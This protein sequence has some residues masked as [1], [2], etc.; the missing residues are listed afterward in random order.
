MA[1]GV[2]STVLHLLGLG[3][4]S[5][6]ILG[7]WTALIVAVAVA[8]CRP[9]VAPTPGL[10]NSVGYAIGVPVSIPTPPAVEILETEPSQKADASGPRVSGPRVPG[11]DPGKPSQPNQPSAEQPDPPTALDLSAPGSAPTPTHLP[12]PPTG[13]PTM[14]PPATPTTVP[15]PTA[16]PLPTATPLPPPTAT[17]LPP[18]TQTPTVQPTAT[19]LPTAT[20]QPT[21]TPR[22]TATPLPPPTPTPT[23]PPPPSGNGCSAGQVDVKSAPVEE[24]DRIKHIGPVRAAEMILIRPFTSLDDLIRIKGIGPKRLADIKAQGLACV[25]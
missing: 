4:R 18:P 11:N 12:P 2:S 23:P 21:S 17:P 16:I 14:V 5:V 3:L 25:A 10:P 13:T 6:L 1:V 9:A 24:L 19:P 8:S 20:P 7:L 15:T 22:P